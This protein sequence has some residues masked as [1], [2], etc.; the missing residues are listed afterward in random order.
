MPS[1]RFVATLSH[2]PWQKYFWRLSTVCKLPFINFFWITLGL[3]CY[4][5]GTHYILCW[6]Q[7]HMRYNLK[8]KKDVVYYKTTSSQTLP[9][10]CFDSEISHLPPQIWLL[11]FFSQEHHHR[12][13]KWWPAARGTGAPSTRRLH[14]AMLSLLRDLTQLLARKQGSLVC[15]C[16]WKTHEATKNVLPMGK[17]LWVSICVKSATLRPKINKQL[18]TDIVITLFFS[19]KLLNNSKAATFLL[20]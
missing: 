16:C 3:V 1:W 6:E 7:N 18:F 13:Y 19:Q 5:S 15:N 12:V 20:L 10:A 8:F 14:S 9:V 4:Q 17:W 2:H 11:Q